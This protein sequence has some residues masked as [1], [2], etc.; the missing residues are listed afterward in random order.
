M[1]PVRAYLAFSALQNIVYASLYMKSYNSRLEHLPF[2]FVLWLET[3]EQEP[4]Y[5]EKHAS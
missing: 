3:L 1:I 4:L 2:F 5:L